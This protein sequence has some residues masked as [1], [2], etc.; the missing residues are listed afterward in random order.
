MGFLAW[1]MVVSDQRTLCLAASVKIQ[2]PFLTKLRFTRPLE[3]FLLH[4]GRMLTSTRSSVA[5]TDTTRRTAL[6]YRLLPPSRA[7][8]YF[9][10]MFL[11]T[12]PLVI[13]PTFVLVP[14]IVRKVMEGTLNYSFL[15]YF[16]SAAQISCECV[17]FDAN[18]ATYNS[19]K[20]QKRPCWILSFSWLV[21]ACLA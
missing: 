4:R 20:P 9:A 12:S 18:T 1:M 6:A 16:N 10:M 3:S 17:P 13:A 2:A 15:I 21:D 8:V 5:T 7:S 14:L 11:E 19:A